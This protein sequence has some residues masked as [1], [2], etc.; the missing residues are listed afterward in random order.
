M[1][2]RHYAVLIPS[3][4]QEN[5]SKSVRSIFESHPDFDP[6]DL[7]VVTG[8]IDPSCMPKEVNGCN[9]IV[10]RAPFVFGRRVNL[11]F[12]AIPHKDIV[13]MGDDV[14]IGTSRAFD[15]LAG[16]APLRL[17]APS[18]H[19]RI[20]PWWQ[21]EGENHP[22]VPFISFTCLYIPRTVYSIVG[23]LEEGFPG[24]GYEDTDYCLRARKAGLSMGVVGSVVIHHSVGIR[25]SFMKIHGAQLPAMES[26]AREAFIEKHRLK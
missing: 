3:D 11:G 9:V 2:R 18:V 5:L 1:S 14:E 7:F 24:Y 8:A 4:D 20:G 22:D 6:A 25:S 12:K 13:L 23:P 17:L 15:L 16:Q 10:D 26:A 21:R 19:G